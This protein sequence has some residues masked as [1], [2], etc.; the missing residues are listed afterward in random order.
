MKRKSIITE[1]T[2]SQTSGFLDKMKLERW[3][4]SFKWMFIKGLLNPLS[5]VGEIY[6]SFLDINLIFKKIYTFSLT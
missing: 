6:E 5:K 2:F 1:D 4:N 3:E